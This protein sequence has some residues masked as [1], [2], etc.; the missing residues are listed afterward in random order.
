MKN[1]KG[2]ILLPLLA[3]IAL[4]AGVSKVI[5]VDVKNNYLHIQ[6]HKYLEGKAEYKVNK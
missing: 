6:P 1:Q 4:T 2:A 5:T 3:L